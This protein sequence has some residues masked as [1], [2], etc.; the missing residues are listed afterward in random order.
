M[1][2]VLLFLGTEPRAENYQTK[3]IV[4]ICSTQF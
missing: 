4:I 2:S 3:Q 1:P